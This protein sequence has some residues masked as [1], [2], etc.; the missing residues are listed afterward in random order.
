[1]ACHQGGVLTANADVDN[2]RAPATST[3]LNNYLVWPI[4]NIIVF[5]CDMATMFGLE[6]WLVSREEC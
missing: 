2:D 6:T 1:M 4:M 5:D 3:R